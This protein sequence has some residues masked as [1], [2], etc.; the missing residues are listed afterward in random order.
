MTPYGATCNTNKDQSIPYLNKTKTRGLLIAAFNCGFI[1]G[2]RELYGS[3][4]LSQVAL[5][6][7]DI[8]SLI[9][10]IEL[11][12]YFIYDDAC[13]LRRFMENKKFNTLSRRAS[14]LVNKTHVIDKLYIRNHTVNTVRCEQTNFWIAKMKHITKHLNYV[15]FCFFLYIIFEEF[16]S[17]KLKNQKAD[18]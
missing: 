17:Y 6:Y 3:E 16:N 5:F 2:Y 7:L 10:P 15:R 9:D 18:E 11:P 1:I 12:E 14:I 4:S 8:V 13:H